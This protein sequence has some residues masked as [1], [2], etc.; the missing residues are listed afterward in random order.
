[1]KRLLWAVMLVLLP[2]VSVQA[3]SV[4]IKDLGKISSWRENSLVGYGLVTG[5]AGSG[6]SARSKATRQSLAN[7]LARYDLAVPSDEIQS[8]NVAAVMITASLPN[9]ARPGDALDVTVA[10]VGDA[11]SLA[12]GTL[13]LAP[14][15]GPD[16][17][18]YAL[19]QGALTVGGYRYDANNNLAQ[20]NHPTVGLVTG[21]ATVEVAIGGAAAPAVDMVTF[22]LHDADYTTAGRIADA[23]NARLGSGIADVRDASAIEIAVPPAYR[24]RVPALMRQLETLAVEP[25]RRARVVVN[26]RTGTI[27]AGGDVRIA[28]VAVSHGD[29]RISVS[30]ETTVSQPALVRQTGPDVR[31]EVVTNSRLS[32]EDR[33]GAKFVPAGVTTVADLVQALVRMKT[34]T[35]DVIA[36]LQAI[37]AAG[38]L[39]ADLIVQ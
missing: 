1:M 22:V 9:H 36:V 34:S 35:R 37:K 29:I 38:A 26:E 33:E 6:D 28:K 32:V 31:T 23:V 39:H 24:D 2:V 13:L 27:V 8:R 12:G 5:L 30:S 3:Q 10:S 7:L 20:K 25:D 4:R 16:G 21:G 14:L 11:R 15:K 19:A 18:V 17:K